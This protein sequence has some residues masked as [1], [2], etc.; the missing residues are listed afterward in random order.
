MSRI[1]QKKTNNP[2]Y[3]DEAL[4]NQLFWLIRRFNNSPESIKPKDNKIAIEEALKKIP[5]PYRETI[6]NN[7]VYDRPYNV[8]CKKSIISILKARFIYDIA[9]SLFLI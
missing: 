9:K 3:I 2:Y 5:E 6:Y 4:Y 8:P 1:Y 7:I